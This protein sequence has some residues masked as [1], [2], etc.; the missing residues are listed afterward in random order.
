MV[1]TFW[2]LRITDAPLLDILYIGETL[3]DVKLTL[4]LVELTLIIKHTVVC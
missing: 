1:R 4:V 3:H 2:L